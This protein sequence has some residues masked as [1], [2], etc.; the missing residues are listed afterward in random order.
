MS[1]QP[2]I[3]EHPFVTLIDSYLSSGE[4]IALPPLC[5]IIVSLCESKGLGGG[6]VLEVSEMPIQQL[7]PAQL[8]HRLR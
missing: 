1:S 4:P 2:S 7:L 6:E 8:A 3:N 5:L